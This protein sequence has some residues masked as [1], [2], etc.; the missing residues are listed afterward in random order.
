MSTLNV[1]LGKFILD[2]QILSFAQFIKCAVKPRRLGRGYKAQSFKAGFV[3][4]EY[5]V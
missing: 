5:I 2:V 4:V 1:H 3:V